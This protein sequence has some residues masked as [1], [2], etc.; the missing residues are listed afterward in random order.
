MMPSRIGTKGIT[1]PLKNQQNY[2]VLTLVI[3]FS[4]IICEV[5][6]TG[7]F[8]GDYVQLGTSPAANGQPWRC[9]WNHL[10]YR[11]IPLP[12]LWGLAV[13]RSIA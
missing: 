13:R 11:L 1:L 8:V 4:E 3:F 10:P 5:A 2:W 9:K 12:M 6:Q 7:R